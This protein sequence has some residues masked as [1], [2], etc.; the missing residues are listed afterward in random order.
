MPVRNYSLL[1]NGAAGS[2]LVPSPAD[3]LITGTLTTSLLPMLVR[4]ALFQVGLEACSDVACRRSAHIIPLSELPLPAHTHPTHCCHCQ[5]MHTLTVCTV[6]LDTSDVQVARVVFF[7]NNVFLTCSFA[8]GSEAQ[9]CR[10]TFQVNQ[11]S[12]E[13]EEFLVLRSEGGQQC[14]TS[15]NQRTAY[16][17]LLVVDVERNGDL[18][19]L[20]ISLAADAVLV[21]ESEEAYREMTGCRVEQGEC[22][23]N[24]AWH[25][26]FVCF[27]RCCD[28]Q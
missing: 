12:S 20:S 1:V 2:T 16:V 9:G 14:N 11:N 22:G 24:I 17:D 13:D 19:Q 21:A 10:F 6:T 26:T 5:H 8:G 4:D 28:G 7:E 15:L 27:C 23:L 18:G 3:V 25:S